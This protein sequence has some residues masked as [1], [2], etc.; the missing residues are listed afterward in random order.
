MDIRTLDLQW[1]RAHV[2]LV[3]QE[4]ALF[5]GSILDNVKLGCPDATLKEVRIACA[6]ANALDF[7][8][9]QPASYGTLLGEGGISLSGGQKQRVA[10]ARALLK[11]P[12]VLLLDEATSALDCESENVVQ[13][14]NN[15][16]HS[17]NP[18]STPQNAQGREF[19]EC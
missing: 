14:C 2:A 19:G 8:E 15:H 9:R 13:V 6:A 16:A 17:S 5:N 7:I 4:P 11:D 1:L 18:P 10:I 3:G 12:R